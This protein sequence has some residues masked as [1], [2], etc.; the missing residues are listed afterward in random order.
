MTTKFPTK[1]LGVGY[2]F[3]CD[4]HVEQDA[5]DADLG[6]QR[7]FTANKSDSNESQS[8]YFFEPDMRHCLFIQAKFES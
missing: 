5:D 4:E 6:F 3:D 1:P 8:C 2:D 7:P